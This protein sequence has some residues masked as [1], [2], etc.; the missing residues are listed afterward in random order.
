MFQKNWDD[1]EACTGRLVKSLYLGSTWAH[2]PTKLDAILEISK[3]LKV[4]MRHSDFI[5]SVKALSYC[6]S[7]LK[8]FKELRTLFLNSP[9]Y[10][11][12]RYYFNGGREGPSR[13]YKEG[14]F[15]STVPKH[16]VLSQDTFPDDFWLPSPNANELL[17]LKEKGA[18]PDHPI[19]YFLHKDDIATTTPNGS[20]P[21]S[22]LE[23]EEEDALPTHKLQYSLNKH[24]FWHALKLVKYKLFQA[25]K[26]VHD[27]CFEYLCDDA[28]YA[29]DPENTTIEVHGIIWSINRETDPIYFNTLYKIFFMHLFY[30]RNWRI[31][32]FYLNPYWKDPRSIQFQYF[33]EYIKAESDKEALLLLW[34]QV[35]LKYPLDEVLIVLLE[36]I[37][38]DLKCADESKAIFESI[39]RSWMNEDIYWVYVR[40]L[41]WNSK[42][43]EVIWMCT[44]GYIPKVNDTGLVV[45]EMLKYFKL[46][47]LHEQEKKLV[48]FWTD[49]KPEWLENI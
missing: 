26:K 15:V 38:I 14:K 2:D 25:K 49:V 10:S 37:S 47:G 39:P 29:I 4:E 9:A 35:Q 5:E 32:F 42:F 13:T 24:F 48:E 28:M 23:L 43:D 1:N 41:V 6:R 20:T 16:Y 27:V 19:Q 8:K 21:S 12:D 44:G 11:V 36:K 46:R 34:E 45:T 7:G 30:S 22:I 18:V 17:E 31:A 3:N 33:I 40:G